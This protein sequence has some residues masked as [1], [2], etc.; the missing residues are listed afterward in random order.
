MEKYHI[1]NDS[2]WAR[3][4]TAWEKVVGFKVAIK[5]YE[6]FD[7]FAHPSLETGEDWVIS[8]GVTGMAIVKGGETK[9][10]ATA[11]AKKK[12]LSQAPPEKLQE[13]ID[14]NVRQYRLSPRYN[15]DIDLENTMTFN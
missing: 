9:Q 1:A 11:L 12:L 6:Q 10:H 5:G 13:H 7:L 2:Y 15:K 3:N 8:E 4:E 14:N